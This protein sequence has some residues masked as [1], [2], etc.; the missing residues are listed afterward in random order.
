MSKWV[1]GIDAG[2]VDEIVGDDRPAELF[3]MPAS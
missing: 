2:R 1:V 3:E